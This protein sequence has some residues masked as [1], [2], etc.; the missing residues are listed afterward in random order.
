MPLDDTKSDFEEDV[1]LDIDT[2]IPH[3]DDLRGRICAQKVQSEFYWGETIEA[4]AQM[5]DRLNYLLDL[6][7]RSDP[8]QS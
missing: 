4:S 7:G 8:S 6:H 1:Q 3:C 2:N 5:I